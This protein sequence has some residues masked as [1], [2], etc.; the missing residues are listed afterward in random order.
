MKFRYLLIIVESS[1]HMVNEYCQ[2]GCDYVYICRSSQKGNRG[3]IYQSDKRSLK[4]ESDLR[5]KSLKKKHQD[6]YRLSHTIHKPSVRFISLSGLISSHLTYLISSQLYLINHDW[7]IRFT[8]S[9][10]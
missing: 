7:I 2:Y 6:I 8:N 9:N 3:I 10:L 5:E 4:L 1:H